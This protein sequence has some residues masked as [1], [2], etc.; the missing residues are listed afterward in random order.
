MVDLTN[1]D[2]GGGFKGKQECKWDGSNS[3]KSVVNY[4]YS[5]LDDSSSDSDLPFSVKEDGGRFVS[6][7][8]KKLKHRDNELQKRCH[9]RKLFESSDDEEFDGESE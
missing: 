7:V 8:K 5:E 6:P 1:D 9:K 2:D 3:K 4:R